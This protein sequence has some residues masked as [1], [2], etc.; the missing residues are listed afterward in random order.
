M[1]FTSTGRS[2][3]LLFIFIA[4]TQSQIRNSWYRARIISPDKVGW[5]TYLYVEG[6]F[7][8]I[9]PPYVALGDLAVYSTRAAWVDGRG[10]VYRCQWSD[11]FF[12]QES[13]SGDRYTNVA[14]PGE[15]AVLISL[16]RCQQS[17]VDFRSLFLSNG[18]PTYCYIWHVCDNSGSLAGTLC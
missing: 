4:P 2:R 13:A 11:W 8:R 12:V 16:L 10:D 14:G 5:G 18:I 7:V 1:Y 15:G 9:V 3:H 17:Q 6:G